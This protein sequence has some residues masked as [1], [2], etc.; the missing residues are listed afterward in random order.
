MNPY[1]VLGVSPSATDDEVK[2]AYRT[3]SKK[4]HPDANIGNP[5]QAQLT[6]KFKEVQT[7][8]KTIMDDRKQGFTNR[9]YTNN[10]GGASQSSSYNYTGNDNQ[11]YSEIDGFIKARRYQEAINILDQIRT[12]N[13]LWFYY[14]AIANNGIGNNITAI[15]YAQTACQ[16]EPMNLN[17]MMLLQQ[18]QGGQR[19]YQNQ[20]STYGNPINNMGN[21]CYSII[22]MNCLLNCCCRGGY[23]C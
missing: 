14:A 11:A 15:E 21:C 7:A 3:L 23:G 4:Y 5:N 8:Y 13:G 9:T 10:Q 22:M 16:M 2:K 1:Q 18:L 19:Q 17:Y 20:S 6:E 12:K